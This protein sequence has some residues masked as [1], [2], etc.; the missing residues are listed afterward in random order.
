MIF[1]NFILIF[2][3]Y[4]L[5]LQPSAS[6][7]AGCAGTTGVNTASTASCSGCTVWAVD[8]AIAVGAPAG[9]SKL[10]DGLNYDSNS[11]S[12]IDFGG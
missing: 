12:K 7:T 3:S 11:G 1:Q 5:P 2:C 9:L 8:A 10:S 6:H 4:I